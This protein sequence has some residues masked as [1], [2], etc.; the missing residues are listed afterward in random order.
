MQTEIFMSTVKIYSRVVIVFNQLPSWLQGVVTDHFISLVGVGKANIHK[1]T[2]STV[3]NGTELL[4][5]PVDLFCECW[6]DE[7]MFTTLEG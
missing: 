4:R 3:I 5:K 6:E 7:I 2:T 1:D